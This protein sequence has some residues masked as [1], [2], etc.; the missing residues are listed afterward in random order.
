MLHAQNEALYDIN[1]NILKIKQPEYEHLNAL[2]AKV[3]SGFTSTFHF[4]LSSIELVI[5]WYPVHDSHLAFVSCQPVGKRPMDAVA[6]CTCVC[7]A[8]V[9]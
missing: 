8:R 5:D 3:M 7:L 6:N 4:S 9:S 2:I 1:Q